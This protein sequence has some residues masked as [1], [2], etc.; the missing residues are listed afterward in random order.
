[1]LLTVVLS[2]LRELVGMPR[3]MKN[4]REHWLEGLGL[5]AGLGIPRDRPEELDEVAGKWVVWASLLR[6]LPS[7]PDLG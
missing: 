5:S 1:M 2:V 6:L 3:H 4:L 7:R